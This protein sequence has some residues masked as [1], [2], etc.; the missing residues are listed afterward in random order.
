MTEQHK[1][2]RLG[3]VTA[4]QVHKILGKDDEKFTQTGETYLYE[5]AAQILTGQTS[6]E[7]FSKAIEWGN[8]YE[9]EAVARLQREYS[10]LPIEYFGIE[11]PQFFSLM[12]FEGFAGG[13]PDGKIGAKYCIEVKCP[14]NSAVHLKNIAITDNAGLK[15]EH[16]E[17]YA[18]IQMNMVCMGC[19]LGLFVSYD[20]RNLYKPL[21][22]VVI[23]HDAELQNKICKKVSLAREFVR[24]I[25]A[26][27]KNKTKIEL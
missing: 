11:N 6:E 18:Q 23:Q 15:S 24:T 21:H 20:P 1:Q 17:Y 22:V 19:E 3:R 25:V 8:T 12:E 27:S 7:V 4:S 14:Y 2:T 13:S 26:Q 10:D 5:V 9:P 16:P